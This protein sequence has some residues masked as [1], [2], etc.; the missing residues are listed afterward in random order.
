MVT[1]IT[2]L[3][4]PNAD[5]HDSRLSASWWSTPPTQ[6]VTIV[7][8]VEAIRSGISR[9]QVCTGRRVRG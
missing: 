2:T 1:S 4:N 7:Q 3:R 6:T 9:S 5:F 8:A